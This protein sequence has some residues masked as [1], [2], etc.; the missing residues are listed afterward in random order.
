M[1]VGLIRF[2]FRGGARE[3]A[4][5]LNNCSN[6]ANEEDIIIGI[7]DN[8]AKGLQEFKGELRDSKFIRV[9]E[10][11]GKNCRIK[12]HKTHDIFGL[13]LPIPP[14]KQN[15]I[16]SEQELNVFSIE[17]YFPRDLLEEEGMVESHP[18][19]GIFRIKDRKG[20]KS[21]FANRVTKLTNKKYFEEFIYLF[22]EIDRLAGRDDIDY[23]T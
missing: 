5:I 14:L 4:N 7:F 8:D 12:K 17:H 18:I 9:D 15:F 3:V 20:S 1:G 6:I 22:Q 21:K 23:G 13:L 16:F 10:T 11:D 19:E 2:G